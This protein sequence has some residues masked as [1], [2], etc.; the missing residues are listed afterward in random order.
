MRYGR[1]LFA[2]EFS[3]T[4]MPRLMM[5]LNTRF[6]LQENVQPEILLTALRDT[7]KLYPVFG[8]TF[9]RDGDKIYFADDDEPVS[10]YETDKIHVPDWVKFGRHLFFVGYCGNMIS[11]SVD[12]RLSDG[13]GVQLFFGK[14]LERYSQLLAGTAEEIIGPAYDVSLML[15][16]NPEIP[17]KEYQLYQPFTC[18]GEMLRL[19]ALNMGKPYRNF[20]CR[21]DE[22]LFMNYVRQHETTALAAISQMIDN[23]IFSLGTFKGDYI[24][25]SFVISSKKALGMER[26]FMN[27]LEFGTIDITHAEANDPSCLKRVC[28]DVKGQI[29]EENIR[30]L[31]LH[32]RDYDPVSCSTYTCSYLR[33]SGVHSELI[34]KHQS[35]PLFFGPVPKVDVRAGGGLMEFI[36]A[37]SPECEILYNGVKAGLVAAGFNILNEECLLIETENDVLTVVTEDSFQNA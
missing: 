13:S 19:P 21:V 35:V 4:G 14:M 5:T 11:I 29:T 28:A 30:A 2:E 31:A 36:V 6:F 8:F 37:G 15:R 34:E 20:I 10:I 22:Q 16:Q 3:K 12:H 1:S 7:L 18:E 24:R 33:L 23:G 26:S 25:T 32:S 17:H 27:L 9:E